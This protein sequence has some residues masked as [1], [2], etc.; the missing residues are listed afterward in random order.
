MKKTFSAY[1][2]QEQ[3]SKQLVVQPAEIHPAIALLAKWLRHIGRMAMIISF[4]VG[5]FAARLIHAKLGF[6]I[7]LPVGI[8]LITT[9]GHLTKQIKFYKFRLAG[10]EAELF[11]YVVGGCALIAL[12]QI[13]VQRFVL[14]TL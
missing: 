14:H 11:A 13:V 7:L 2:V 6:M 10:R 9:A 5:L 1:A 12:I 4:I 8:I 3:K